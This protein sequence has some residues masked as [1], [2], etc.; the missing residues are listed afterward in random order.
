MVQEFREAV[1]AAADLLDEVGARFRLGD[2]AENLLPALAARM[3]DIELRAS[4][5][6][7]ELPLEF[8]TEIEGLLAR[9]RDVVSSGEGWLTGAGGIEL[10]S[11]HLRQRVRKVYRLGPR[12]T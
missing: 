8:R 6:G 12:T 2:P 10:A 1:K 4:L 7:P 9:L 5:V 3:A 11:H